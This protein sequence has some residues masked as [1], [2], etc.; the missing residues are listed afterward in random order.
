MAIIRNVNT[1]VINEVKQEV[2]EYYLTHERDNYELVEAVEATPAGSS[3]DT[4]SGKGVDE[5]DYPE[6][7]ALAKLLGIPATGGKDKLAAAIKEAQ[8]AE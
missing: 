3:E 7:Q 4:G 5:M 6:L 8:A 2:A 1:G